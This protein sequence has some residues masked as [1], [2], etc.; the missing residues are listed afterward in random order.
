MRL[1][2]G[3]FSLLALA[4]VTRAETI[5]GR[6]I[7]PNGQPTRASIQ[8]TNVLAEGCPPH[9]TPEIFANQDGS[10]MF[11]GPPSIYSL[12]TRFGGH[13]VNPDFRKIDTRNGSV[14]GV[15]IQLRSGRW[16]YG[17]GLP[18]VASRIT[19]G[20]PNENNLAT[21][22]GAAGAVAPDALVALITLD[23]GHYA[24][25]VADDSGA[26][27]TTLFAPRGSSISVKVDDVGLDWR[28]LRA[29]PSNGCGPVYGAI[30][31]TIVRAAPPLPGPGIPFET[32]STKDLSLWQLRG[33]IGAQHYQRGERVQVDATLTVYAKSI[34]TKTP[35]QVILHTHLEAIYVPGSLGTRASSL[36]T[37]HLMTPTG[38]PIERSRR[39]QP[40]HN[41]DTYLD[42]TKVADDRAVGSFTVSFPL[43]ADLPDGYYRLGVST[44][45][46]IPAT[47]G[48][49]PTFQVDFK[50][51]DSARLPIFRVGA[52]PPPRIP[53]A[54]LMDHYSNA[55]QGIRA[56]EDRQRFGIA[57]R[58]ATQSDTFVV[59]RLHPISGEV[60]TYR[61][62]PFLPS[63]SMSDRDP[64][65][66]P[67]I[68]F[69]LP[70]GEVRVAIT[71]S[72]GTSETI[73]PLPLL[74]AWPATIVNRHG[75]TFDGGG[76]QITEAYRLTTLDPRF[77][78]VF[79][80]DGLYAV[81][82]EVTIDDE[83]GNRWTGEGTFEIT[84]ATPLV[85][86]TTILPGTP[87]EVGDKLAIA[88]EILPPRAADIEAVV[89]LGTRTSTVRGRANAFG[90][91]S[92][93]PIALTETGEYRID[94]TAT[95]RA[96]SGAMTAGARTWGGVV[97]PRAPS[98]VA[99]GARG[100]DG[101]SELRPQWFFHSALGVASADHVPFPFFSGD[102]SW[103][104][105]DH[106]SIP[107][108]TFQDLGGSIVALLRSRH[109]HDS[110]LET[111]A[112]DGEIPFFSESADGRDVHLDPSRVDLWSYAYTSVQRPL[113]RVREEIG[114]LQL[115]G[116]YWRFSEQYAAQMGVGPAGDRLN[117]FKFQFGGGVIRGA[118]VTV[119]QF[120]IYGSLWVMVP[121]VDPAGGTRT[122]P[123][124]QG[125]GG[126]PSGGPLFRL[127]GKDID[128]FFHPTGVRPGTILTRGQR[129]RFAGYAAPPLAAKVE[130]VI[131]SPS[132]ASR[133]IAGKANRI[134][135]FYD[136]TADFVVSESGVWRVKAKVT[137][138]G[139]TS[140]GPVAPP[141]P[142][143][144]IL[145]SREGEFFFYVVDA[146]TQQL[147]IGA[148]PRFVEAAKV[149]LVF[150]VSTPVPLTN[151]TLCRTVMMP[152]W[153]LDEGCGPSLTWTYDAQS[154][155][156]DFPN[157]DID[158]P[159]GAGG[160]DAVTI[161]LFATGTDASGTV[162]HFARRVLVNAGEVHTSG[163][164]AP[165]RR[166]AV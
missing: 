32:W 81:R 88:G 120:D 165:V 126:G 63:V 49:H 154:L 55:T 101:G 30:P 36:L 122:F 163:Q 76:G 79:A 113:I 89:T 129:A 74:Q 127:K 18:P 87:F 5:T 22:R 25:A 96:S 4:A 147:G 128:L 133:T 14:S 57:S 108:L 1:L 48:E 111:A 60:L 156:R 92:L 83:L 132:G 29:G 61:L 16:S 3:A 2:A 110:W 53:L 62:E 71:R 105:E 124:F 6:V 151:V 82:A 103:V 93:D 146:A 38:F 112:T 19:V 143:G 153:I 106:S 68:P 65:E 66:I 78:V 94:I 39:H 150:T 136:D 51:R 58:I 80:G 158:D 118:A 139:R 100:T 164:K 123:P 17:A 138:D 69:R 24:T 11:D 152:G 26:F 41:I 140:F 43:P 114:E 149:P 75:N 34:S 134:G 67:M 160:A 72:D 148:V 85:V 42:L 99:H 97:A 145:G 84:V 27:E 31:G 125:N 142:T 77:D 56:R 119:P 44:Q 109:P 70:S 13:T 10:F 52:P 107:A 137:V 15:A 155:A 46:T 37:S 117:D 59:P 9:D 86:D 116:G 115:Q 54:L 102:V 161:S 90:F 73:G 91:F 12:R 20:E 159:D 144:D 35:L 40:Q 135:W 64:P 33:S 23:T 50:R 47:P 21:V 28:R 131:T 141:Y 157:L 95:D 45:R 8:V 121:A 166:R 162:H 98:I 7:M 104:R 130:L